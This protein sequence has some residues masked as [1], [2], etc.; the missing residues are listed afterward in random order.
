M[1]KAIVT[2]ASKG[3]GWGAARS[4]LDSGYA[5]GITGREVR[6]LQDLKSKHS[7]LEIQET[8][9]RVPGATGKVISALVER[10]GGLDALIL[11][12]PPP[13]KGKFEDLTDQDWQVSI[14]GTL[15]MNLEAIR[16][17]LPALKESGSGR[18]VF[19]LST[20]AKEPIDGLLI[21]S[22]LRAGLLGLAKSLSREFAPYGITVN[23][24]LPGY[25][26]TP[27]LSR[28][29]TAGKKSALLEKVPAR[30]MGD[31]RDQGAMRVGIFSNTNLSREDM[32]VKVR[33]V[34]PMS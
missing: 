22:T 27:G 19:V 6:D 33:A 9:H 25:T 31:P 24:L 2:A 13:G 17:A 28:V 8:D 11:N 29:L 26:E 1:R 32:V 7:S 10:L 5:V 23:A 30:R 3:I 4:L 15:T 34:K 21:S 14:Q 16:A 18:L 20:A 12:S